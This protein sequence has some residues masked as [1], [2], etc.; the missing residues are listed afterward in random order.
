MFNI[1][2]SNMENII[3]TGNTKEEN[4]KMWK[5][6]MLDEMKN[7]NKK[8]IGAFNK[9]E[10]IGYFLYKINKNNIVLDEIQIIKNHQGDKCTFIKLFKYLLKD[11]NIKD[12]YIVTTYVNKNNNKSKAIVKKF[13]FKVLEKKENGNKY[14]INKFKYLKDKLSKYAI[15][16]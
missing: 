8:W 14:I 3:D 5:N 4:Y 2:S 10:L 1:I 6:A 7:K 16:Q 13:G 15:N 11:N 12:N 9:N